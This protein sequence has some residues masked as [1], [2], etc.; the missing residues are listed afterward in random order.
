MSGPITI[1]AEAQ[2]LLALSE[3]HVHLTCRQLAILHVVA[4]NPGLSNVDIVAA[5]GI[6]KPVVT[7]MGDAL[8]PLGLVHRRE[9]PDDRRR[10][11]I[12]ITDEGRRLIGGA[13]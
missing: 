4:A 8:I 11:E 6:P 3:R 9:N 7:R 1:P 5:T 10:V 13:A 2:A 12:T